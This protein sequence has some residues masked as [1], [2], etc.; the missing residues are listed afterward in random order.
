MYAFCL[1]A[2]LDKQRGIR[3]EIKDFAARHA[4]ARV[5][6]AIFES[7]MRGNPVT[8]NHRKYSPGIIAVADICCAAYLAYHKKQLLSI[9][10]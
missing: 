5:I 7:M 6:F 8:Q 9:S 3:P 1:S 4:A 2:A 10:C